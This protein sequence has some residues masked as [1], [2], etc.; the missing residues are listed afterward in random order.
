MPKQ[1]TGRRLTTV[2]V[3]PLGERDANAQPKRQAPSASKQDKPT[4]KQPARS[5]HSTAATASNDTTSSPTQ[6]TSNSNY[7]IL[8]HLDDTEDPHV[9]RLLSIPA[10]FT[11]AQVHEVLQVAFNWADCHM[12][13]FA[14]WTSDFKGA[15]MNGMPCGPNG[16]KQYIK[17]EDPFD[18]GG[19]SNDTPAAND[20][21][22]TLQDV[23]EDP[24][25]GGRAVIGYEYDMGDS[26]MHVFSLVGRACPDGNPQMRAPAGLRV[27][28]L[29][30]EGH[31]VA[32]DCGGIPGWDELKACFKKGK[33][34][35]PD[36]RRAWYKEECM[37]GEKDFDPYKWSILDVNEQL[38]TKFSPEVMEEEDG[39]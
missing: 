12:H 7:L 24:K 20:T 4:Q 22:I 26:W 1:P 15:Y 16:V 19:E 27:F 8:V 9:Q 39:E 33:R 14:V 3:N 21:N 30:G 29:A 18:L 37:N 5:Q 2:R 34:G 28:C 32:E 35:D 23:Y 13:R 11:F 36:D 31:H 6:P 10:S 25:Y 38:A 17:R